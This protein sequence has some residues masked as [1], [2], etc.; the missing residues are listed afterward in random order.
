MSLD[1]ISYTHGTKI[2]L[3][4]L[5]LELYLY[6]IKHPL[7][8]DNNPFLANKG[9]MQF[10]LRCMER[11][12]LIT[13]DIEGLYIIQ[14]EGILDRVI[15]HLS[16]LNNRSKM[17]HIFYFA[18]TLSSLV[19]FFFYILFLPR[20]LFTTESYLLGFALFSISSLALEIITIRRRSVIFEKLLMDNYPK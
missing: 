10:Y 4:G 16:R 19:I 1:D 3:K 13:K 20:T 11:D 6:M 2:K 12:G 14:E 15:T 17:R 18:F 8:P 7:D 9:D 5:A